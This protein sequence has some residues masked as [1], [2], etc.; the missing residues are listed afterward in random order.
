[1]HTQYGEVNETTR[2]FETSGIS[3]TNV[4]KKAFLGYI[5][6][7]VQQTI[8]SKQGGVPTIAQKEFL[9]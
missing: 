4:I 5:G 1:M 6:Q 3:Q 2:A 9:A 7:N 8:D